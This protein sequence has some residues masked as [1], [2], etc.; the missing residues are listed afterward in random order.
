LPEQ[1]LASRRDCGLGRQFLSFFSQARAQNGDH[2]M[3]GDVQ[4]TASAINRGF[5]AWLDG[6]FQVLPNRNGRYDLLFT[7]IG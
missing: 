1:G 5:P 6:N 3:L 4:D 2:M 7:D